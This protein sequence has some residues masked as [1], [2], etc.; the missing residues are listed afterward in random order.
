[1]NRLFYVL[2]GLAGLTD[3]VCKWRAKRQQLYLRQIE[4]A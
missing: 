4:A 3:T 1:M 2:L